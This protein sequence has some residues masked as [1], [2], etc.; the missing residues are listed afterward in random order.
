MGWDSG[1]NNKEKASWAPE[2][3][4]LLSFHPADVMMASCSCH[5]FSAKMKLLLKEKEE[6]EEEKREK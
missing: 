1:M 3:I 5:A 6:R 2:F 4:T